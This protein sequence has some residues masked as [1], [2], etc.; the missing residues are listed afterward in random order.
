MNPQWGHSVLAFG[1][2]KFILCNSDLGIP[3]KAADFFALVSSE[4]AI[5]LSVEP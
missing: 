5:P 1:P 3:L 4:C 2:D